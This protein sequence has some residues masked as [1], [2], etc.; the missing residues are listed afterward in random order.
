MTDKLKSNKEEHLETC[1]KFDEHLEKTRKETIWKI[2][3]C[4]EIIK[5]RISEHAVNNLML[6]LERKISDRIKAVEK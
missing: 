3:E 1:N 4:E 5:T 6:V 2:K